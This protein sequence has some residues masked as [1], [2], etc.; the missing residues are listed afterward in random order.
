MATDGYSAAIRLGWIVPGDPP[1]MTELGAK[2]WK[3]INPE[4]TIDFY[5]AALRHERDIAQ[6][7]RTHET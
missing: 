7:E 5:N 2:M 1:E 4:Y 3:I 6:L